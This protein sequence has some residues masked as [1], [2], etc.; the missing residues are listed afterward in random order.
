M[1]PPP[2]QQ[3]VGGVCTSSAPPGVRAEQSVAAGTH[4]ELLSSTSSVAASG[5]LIVAL[6]CDGGGAEAD[7]PRW[8]WCCSTA[9]RALMLVPVPGDD[10]DVCC[11]WCCQCGPGHAHHLEPPSPYATCTSSI[12]IGAW[13]HG[14]HRN[15]GHMQQQLRCRHGRVQGR[16]SLSWPPA[17]TKQA[18]LEPPR[19]SDTPTPTG[20]GGRCGPVK[21]ACPLPAIGKGPP[22]DYGAHAGPAGPPLHVRDASHTARAL[23]HAA[24]RCGMHGADA[25]RAFPDGLNLQEHRPW[26]WVKGVLEGVGVPAARTVMCARAG[27]VA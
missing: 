1:K 2:L 5:M 18:P 7:A 21:A 4:V 17:C 9:P 19:A 11:C 22:V 25:L 12:R 26:L 27:G 14:H 10:A 13:S 8:C 20:R 3:F 15:Q 23:S 6:P 24:L 16:P